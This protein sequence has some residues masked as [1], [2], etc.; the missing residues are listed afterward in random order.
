MH[1]LA[2]DP[3][4]AATL[5][6]LKSILMDGWDPEEINRKIL[7]SQAERLFLKTAP[8]M[9]A[10]WNFVARTGDGERYVRRGTGGVDGTKA[11]RRLPRIDP[12]M[13]DFP[14]L[15]KDDVAAI[16]EN[17]MPLPDHLTDGGN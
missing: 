14:V 2:N 12:I 10:D 6:Q 5:E 13:P 16:L 9:P 3:T 7:Q 15:S 1:N 11:N 17:R 4:N 8:G